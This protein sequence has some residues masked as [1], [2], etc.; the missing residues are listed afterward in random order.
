MLY[1]LSILLCIN[2]SEM[3]RFLLLVVVVVEGGVFSD[4]VTYRSVAVP[5]IPYLV[6]G[7]E[8]RSTQRLRGFGRGVNV[9][10]CLFY[11][12]GYNRYG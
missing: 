9:G 5:A 8:A 1:T 2:P 4:S 11:L 3:F 10:F 7:V 12:P 6:P